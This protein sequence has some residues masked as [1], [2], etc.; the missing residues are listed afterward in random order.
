M[1][2]D[3]LFLCTGRHSMPL[4]PPLMQ[5]SV[6]WHETSLLD[7]SRRYQPFLKEAL[8]FTC[9]Q[10]KSFENIVGKQEIAHS[11]QF[12][13]FPECF[14][15]LWRT[16]CNFHPIRNCLLQICPVWKSLKFVIWERVKKKLYK[17]VRK[18]YFENN[19]GKGKQESHDGPVSLHW[20][21]RKIPSY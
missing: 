3:T 5:T 9:L 11:E 14:Q 2:S 13:L 18:K 21:I 19:M 7:K 4:P 20:L 8:I 6:K 12:L 1:D 10:Y 15:P 17:Y 16:F